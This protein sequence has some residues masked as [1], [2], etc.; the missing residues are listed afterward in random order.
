MRTS[1]LSA[2]VSNCV[3]SR[4]TEAVCG[5][6]VALSLAV[7]GRTPG[8]CAELQLPPLREQIGEAAPA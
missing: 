8:E 4:T 7:G 1:W 5:R 6:G 3:E 2:A